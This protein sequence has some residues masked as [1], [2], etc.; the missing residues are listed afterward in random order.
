MCYRR[1]EYGS[2]SN[3]QSLERSSTK[4]DLE[5]AQKEVDERS[6]NRFLFFDFAARD[7]KASFRVEASR[8]YS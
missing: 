6:G 1:K 7:L 4:E 8:S 3:I 5:F 2:R